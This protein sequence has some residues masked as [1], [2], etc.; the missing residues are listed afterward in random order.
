MLEIEIEDIKRAKEVKVESAF[1]I[2]G[3]LDFLQVGIVSSS[4][5]WLAT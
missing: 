3:V 5:K 4:G 1:D 2:Y